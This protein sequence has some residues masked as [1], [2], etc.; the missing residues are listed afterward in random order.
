MFSSVSKEITSGRLCM[1]CQ[2]PD[3][4]LAL[5]SIFCLIY[6]HDMV[7]YTKHSSNRLSADDTI[8]RK[9]ERGLRHC[10]LYIMIILT[11]ENDCEKL[12]E[13]LQALEK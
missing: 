4:V 9:T 3:S 10:K 13:H 5:G 2:A 12:Q 8:S 7:E 11:V 6:I 1:G